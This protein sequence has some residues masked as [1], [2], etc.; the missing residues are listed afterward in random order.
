MLDGSDLLPPFRLHPEERA[1]EVMPHSKTEVGSYRVVLKAREIS[2]GKDDLYFEEPVEIKIVATDFPAFKVAPGPFQLTIGDSVS[3]TL[4]SV[5]NPLG[6]E[7]SLSYEEGPDWLSY[8]KGSKKFKMSTDLDAFLDGS[9][10]LGTYSA[11]MLWNAKGTQQFAGSYL[12]ASVLEQ[13]AADNFY[14]RYYFD[15][16]VV[17]MEAKLIPQVKSVS[18]M[19][20]YL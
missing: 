4:P 1:F 8:Q 3:Y 15:V 9:F 11:L 2:E 5:D 18:N 16:E 14:Q 7:Y 12:G 13:G 20:S 6:L 17:D 10:Q 19:T